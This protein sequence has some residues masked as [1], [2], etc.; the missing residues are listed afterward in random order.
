M[1]EAFKAG[2][3][4]WRPCC[5]HKVDE[6][7]GGTG[8]PGSGGQWL[9]ADWEYVVAF[10]SPGALR[11]ADPTFQ[12]IPPKCPP[13][14]AIRNRQA[15]GRREQRKWRNPSFVNP[16]NVLRARVGGGH[17][18][19]SECHETEAPFPER[20]AAFFIQAYTPVGGVVVDPFSGSGTTVCE[21]VRLGRNGIGFD[22]RASQVELARRRLS[23]RIAEGGAGSA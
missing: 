7:G 11:F 22:I 4:L 10:K 3:E 17:M 19:D 20:L 5:W 12:K 8:I 21:A 15:S 16:G 18:G 2:I 6:E 13:G 9:R 1:H 23:R 14:G